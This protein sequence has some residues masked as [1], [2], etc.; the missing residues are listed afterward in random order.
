MLSFHS[1][2]YK[3]LEHSFSRRIKCHTI[4]TEGV[5]EQIYET[6]HCR[7]RTV[8]FIDNKKK[9]STKRRVDY[10]ND[11]FTRYCNAH[12]RVDLVLIQLSGIKQIPDKYRRWSPVTWLLIKNIFTVLMV[13]HCCYGSDTWWRWCKQAKTNKQ[14]KK[15]FAKS[16][17]LIQILPQ[18]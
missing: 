10:I 15:T 3:V 14:A 13:R 12:C 9:D 7:L 17:C 2:T 4:C 16:D 5:A 1:G 8:K 6:S 18:M 11:L